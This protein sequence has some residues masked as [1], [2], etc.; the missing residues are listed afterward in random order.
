MANLVTLSYVDRFMCALVDNAREHP[1]LHGVQVTS[2]SLGAATDP[3]MAIALFTA[4]QNTDWAD[5]GASRRRE[6]FVVSGRAGVFSYPGADE[7]AIRGCRAK[8]YG[9]VNALDE[10]LRGT[11]TGIRNPDAARVPTCKLAAITGMAL[12]QGATAEGRWATIMFD[13]TAWAELP[14]L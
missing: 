14:R 10:I 8:V 4:D 1:T 5:I 6:D 7:E 3:D 13:I 2:G 9:L 12:D 11:T